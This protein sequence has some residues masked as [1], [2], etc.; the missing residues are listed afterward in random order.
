LVYGPD[1]NPSFASRVDHV[2]AH[3]VDDVG[4]PIHGV[5]SGD[6]LAL[7]DEAWSIAQNGGA[8]AIQQGQPTSYFVNMGRDV[9]YVG[10]QAGAAAGNPSVSY[11]QIVVQNGNE[12][13]TSFP[14]SGIPI[15]G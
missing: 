7:T 12:V 9:G 4:R 2:L 14:V 1:P 8:V 3:G 13:V 5:F 6:A 11:I 10:G 15:G